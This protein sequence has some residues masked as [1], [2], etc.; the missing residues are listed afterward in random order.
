MATHDTPQSMSIEAIE[1]YLAI[2]EYCVTARKPL[3][4]VYGYP[5]VLLLCCVIDAWSNYAGHS[6]NSLGELQSILSLT[7]KQAKDFKNWYRNL[8]AHQAIIMPGTQ[9]WPDSDGNA[10]EFGPQGEPTVIR[11]GPFHRAVRE[12]WNQFDKASVKPTFREAQAPKAAVT[13]TSKLF[14]SSHL[15]R[16][17]FPEYWQDN[18]KKS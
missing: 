16:D 6:E 17:E 11:V 15:H 18:P 5:A 10:I 12:W 13:E 3:G 8:L 7:P 2:A 4:G 1:E 14:I 9:L